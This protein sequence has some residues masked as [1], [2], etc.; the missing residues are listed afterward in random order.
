MPATSFVPGT[1]VGRTIVTFVTEGN[2]SCLFD[3]ELKVCRTRVFHTFW[4]SRNNVVIVP[5]RGLPFPISHEIKVHMAAFTEV[6][7]R[8]IVKHR[9]YLTVPEGV[10]G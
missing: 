9:E 1:S 10:G 4:L 2:C 6:Q 8:Q 5:I 3:A 7:E